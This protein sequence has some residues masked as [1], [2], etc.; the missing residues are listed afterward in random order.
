MID[1]EKISQK[2]AEALYEYGPDLP[3]DELSGSEV[4]FETCQ[5]SEPQPEC[6]LRWAKREV[7]ELKNNG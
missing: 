6:W 2:L 1:Y 3:C 7:E 5:Y 4:C